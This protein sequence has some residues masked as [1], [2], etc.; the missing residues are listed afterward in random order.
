MNIF[1]RTAILASVV[2]AATSIF[3]TSASANCQPGKP[4]LNNMDSQGYGTGGSHQQPSSFN[5]I[6][7]RGYANVSGENFG[8]FHS[9]VPAEVEGY[10]LSEKT[11]MTDVQSNFTQDGAENCLT[12]GDDRDQM[13]THLSGTESVG[14]R[15]FY[16]GTP[17]NPGQP[18][19]I[20]AKTNA[21][22]VF[23]SETR[24]E[25]YKNVGQ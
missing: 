2:I 4:C 15:G 10:T 3:A 18:I 25:R 14:M 23:D 24:I 19:S 6:K 5:A 20:G 1:R 21:G 13:K 12:C 9:N 8:Q 16:N 17:A 22:M 11:V 7:T